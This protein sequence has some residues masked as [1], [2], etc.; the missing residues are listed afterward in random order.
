MGLLIAG[1]AHPDLLRFLD[2]NLPKK[3]KKVLLG[4]NDQKLAGALADLEVKLTF[5]GVT[6]VRMNFNGM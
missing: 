6:Q 1:L 2:E 5:G 3:K 4:V